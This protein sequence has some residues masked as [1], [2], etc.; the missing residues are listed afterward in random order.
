M[1]QKRSVEHYKDHELIC[2]ASPGS[3]GWRYTISI[4]EHKGDNSI[5]HSEASDETFPSDTL[6]LQAAARHARSAVDQLTQN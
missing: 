3:G 2:I 6:A 4:V 5:V 1:D